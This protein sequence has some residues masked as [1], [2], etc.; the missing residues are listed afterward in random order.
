MFLTSFLNDSWSSETGS[1]LP[2]LGG[3]LE[4]HSLEECIESGF[5]SLS[6]PLD[7]ILVQCSVPCLEGGIPER[8]RVGLHAAPT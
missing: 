2:G 5:P 7:P 8:G 6:P 3:P 1:Q 4:A